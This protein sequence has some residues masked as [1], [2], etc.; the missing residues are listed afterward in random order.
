MSRERTQAS[1]AIAVAVSIAFA[2]LAH[3]AVIDG[4]TPTVGALLSLL[5]LA[6]LGLWATR[7]P[8]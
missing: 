5:P 3:F 6:I 8:P 2:L 1:V 7:Q 4:L